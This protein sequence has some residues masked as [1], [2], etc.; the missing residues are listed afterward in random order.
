MTKEINVYIEENN[1]NT[2]IY[3]YTELAHMQD[4]G[5]DKIDGLKLYRKQNS[6]HTDIYI[7]IKK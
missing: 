3:I 1:V 2:C 5:I 7:Y 6:T 4:K